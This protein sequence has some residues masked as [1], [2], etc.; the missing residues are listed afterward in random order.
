MK[1]TKVCAVLVTCMLIVTMSFSVISAS[2]TGTAMWLDYYGDTY[3]AKDVVLKV[4]GLNDVQAKVDAKGNFIFDIDLGDGMRDIE[5]YRDGELFL[6]QSTEIKGSAKLEI[7]V[8]TVDFTDLWNFSSTGVYEGW[9]GWIGTIENHGVG[10]GCFVGS[11]Q[12][13]EE[14]LRFFHHLDASIPGT[15]DTAVIRF[16]CDTAGRVNV[17]FDQGGIEATTPQTGSFAPTCTDANGWK[18]VVI[19]VNV[20]REKLDVIKSIRVAFAAGETANLWVDY[21]GF[22]NTFDL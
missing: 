3:P 6:V 15:I 22:G 12:G 16:K 18:I 7:L 14:W 10:D 5:I 1:L 20:H 4:A 11:L 2:T 13:G 8:P 21:I 19:P 9:D 17:W